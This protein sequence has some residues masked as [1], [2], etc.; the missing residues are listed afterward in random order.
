[1]NGIP[2]AGSRADCQ[3]LVVGASP[4]GLVLAAELLAR[5]IRTR[6]ID[7]GDGVAL[8][9]RAIGIHARTLE[10]L[11]MMDLA[12]RF[13]ERGQVVRQFRF[14]SQGRCLTSLEFARCGSRFGF[15]LDLPQDETER[16]LRSRV[17]EL[18][19]VVEDGTE[20]AGLSAGSDAVT[21]TVRGHGGQVQDHRRVRRRLR[22]R[23]Q[24]GA[25]RARPDLQ[26]APLPA[27]MAAGRCAAGLGPA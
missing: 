27:G 16:L 12:E 24:P 18:G 3:V 15:L 13:I 21:A 2:L 1:M 25:Q 11:D 20:L 23:A 5:G 4:T 6:V 8:Q 17:T 14:Y 19:G 22:R 26:R 9:S 7:R 10:V